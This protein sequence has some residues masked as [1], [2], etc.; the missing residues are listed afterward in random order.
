MVVISDDL[1]LGEPSKGAGGSL[2]IAIVEDE[3]TA[4]DRLQRMTRE[5]LGN[6][7]AG[8]KRFDHLETAIDFIQSSPI[9]LLL[10]DLNLHGRDGF[11][12]LRLS[13]AGSFH[14]II[15]SAYADQALRAFEHGVLDF[16]AK[17]YGKKRLQQAFDRFLDQQGVR[18]GQAK[19]LAVKKTGKLEILELVQVRYLK[20]ADYYSEIVL[21]DGRVKLHNK[22]LNKLMMILPPS[23]ARIHKSYI[24]NMTEAVK[25]R[26]LGGS[27]Y[28]LELSNGE[29]LPVG[30]TKYK[31]LT[32]RF[33]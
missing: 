25:I 2:I 15:V 31:E 7:I 12:L 21:K 33:M 14:T 5:I 13:A 11:E 8:L 24:V 1:V 26:A 16:V 30:R 20:G 17:P 32:A 23:F 3:A 22:T 6:R 4:S 27:K 19:Y 29:L 18:Q 28:D 9:D 10:L